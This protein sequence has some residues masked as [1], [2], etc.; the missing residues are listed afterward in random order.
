MKT[1]NEFLAIFMLAVSAF[2]FVSCNEDGNGGGSNGGEFFEITIDG[3]TTVTVLEST[4]ISGL[5]EF[6]FIS[7]ADVEGVDFMLTTYS[8]LEKLA[9]SAIGEYRFCPS[10]EPQNLD[11]EV[12]VYDEDYEYTYCKNGTHTVT[13]IRRR[14][15]E[16]IVEGEFNGV[17]RDGRAISGK[18]R[19]ASY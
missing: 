13:S 1:I 14:G 3:Q 16:V 8:N 18:Y 12:S 6:S 4:T 5:R 7:S 17:L 2:G 15:E 11:F 10:G 9:A 19:Q